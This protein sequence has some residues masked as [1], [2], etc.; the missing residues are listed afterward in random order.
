M[1]SRSDG[2]ARK[3]STTR[4]D[5]AV[6]ERPKKPD[7]VPSTT[8]KTS[9]MKATLKPTNSETLHALQ[10]AAEH[11][12][13]HPV[14]AEREDERRR[15]HHRAQVGLQGRLQRQ[16]GRERGQE[17]DR[18]EDQQG[19]LRA[20]AV[21]TH[22]QTREIPRPRA[23]RAETV[24]E[25]VARRRRRALTGRRR[26]VDPSRESVSSWRTRQNFT[27]GSSLR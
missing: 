13:A 14:G 15:L 17:Q 18:H 8:P 16:P 23:R 2:K 6:D 11:V 26:A 19:D 9:E 12:A 24:G 21:A 4:H 1:A 20:F 7:T 3:M 22:A 27:R 25:L 10:R 5:D